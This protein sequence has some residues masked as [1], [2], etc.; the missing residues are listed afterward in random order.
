MHQSFAKKTVLVTPPA[1]IVNNSSLTTAEIDTYGYDYCEITVCL[2]A[3]DIALTALKVQESNVSGSGFADISGLVFGTSAN[4]TGSASTLP[5]STDDNGIYKFLIDLKNNRK[6]YLD[7]VA[8]VGNGSTGAFV[9]ILAELS[10][11]SET[12]VTAV[13]AGLKQRLVA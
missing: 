10:R 13:E 4:D 3:T 9:T 5:S 2:G 1:A 12:P 6:R 11:A 8:T 7:V